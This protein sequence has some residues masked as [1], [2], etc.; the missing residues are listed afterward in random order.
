MAGANGV[1]KF[2]LVDREDY[3]PVLRFTEIEGK[4][5]APFTITASPITGTQFAHDLLFT[6]ATPNALVGPNTPELLVALR[7]EGINTINGSQFTIVIENTDPVNP[8]TITFPA[9]SGTNGTYIPNPL[10]IPP[11]SYG[12]YTFELGGMNGPP[13]GHTITLKSVLLSNGGGGGPAG[14]TSF[15]GRTGVVVSA[16]G[17]YNSTE[18]TNLS[19]VPGAT[20]TAALNNLLIEPPG[21]LNDIMVFNGTDW[22]GSTAYPTGRVTNF[23]TQNITDTNLAV[24]GSGAPIVSIG[25]WQF[26]QQVSVPLNTIQWLYSTIWQPT[27]LNEGIKIGRAHV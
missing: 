6:I 13:S 20:V 2:Q 26:L 1:R 16:A 22:V 17:D 19:T 7:D 12:K 11:N 23:K 15:E 5:Y 9:P 4:I 8:K 10:V 14:V 3:V 27:T 21:V 25:R 18:I 24:P